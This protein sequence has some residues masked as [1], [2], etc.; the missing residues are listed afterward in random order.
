MKW[1]NLVIGIIADVSAVGAGGICGA[2]LGRRVPA[3]WKTWLNQIFGVCA[4]GIGISAIVLMENMPAVVLSVILGTVIGLAL[5]LEERIQ[6]GG[7][8]MER[9]LRHFRAQP[10]GAEEDESLSLLVTAIVL[11]CSSG[12]G[13]YGC[14]DAGMTNNATVLLAKA[15]LDFFTAV[16]FASRIGAVVSLIALPQFCLFTALFFL[17]RIIFPLT[18]PVLINDFK[19]AGGF[20]LI[21]TGCRIAKLGDFPIADMIPA[22]G[23]VMP[24]SWL[25][26]CFM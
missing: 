17:A 20:L 18:T 4:M 26:T 19:A 16:I 11:F 22:M 14:L 12:T 10:S 7:R 24:V 21:A 15:V 23:I 13:I 1:G 3:A 6:A 9:A 25:W 2:I 5:R 8:Q